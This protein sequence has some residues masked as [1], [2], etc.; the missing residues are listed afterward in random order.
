MTPCV[1]QPGTLPP[2]SVPHA[3]LPAWTEA[4]AFIQRQE[5]GPCAP[6]QAEW[7]EKTLE[8]S[9]SVEVAGWPRGQRA[10]LIAGWSGQGMPFVCPSAPLLSEEGC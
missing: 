10:H 4:S 1:L 6:G 3:D 7:A 5:S 8:G 9:A 2:D